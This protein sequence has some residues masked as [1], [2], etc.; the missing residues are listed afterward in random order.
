MNARFFYYTKAK[1]I[2][3]Q[4]HSAEENS[5]FE[6]AALFYHLCCKGKSAPISKLDFIWT[7]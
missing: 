1:T 6:I 7:E 5:N 3:E 4:L 2:Y